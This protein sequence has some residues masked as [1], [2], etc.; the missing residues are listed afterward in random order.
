MAKLWPKIDELGSL[1]ETRLFAYQASLMGHTYHHHRRARGSKAHTTTWY[2]AVQALTLGLPRG[3]D[4]VLGLLAVRPYVLFHW[5]QSEI[6]RWRDGFR[7]ISNPSYPLP[8]Q[9]K[10]TSTLLY[11]HQVQ[12]PNVH[13][14]SIHSNHTPYTR[15]SKHLAYNLDLRLPRLRPHQRR[16]P[17]P[18]HHVRPRLVLV[19]RLKLEC[20]CVVRVLYDVFRFLRC[21]SRSWSFGFG[22]GF[23]FSGGGGRCVGL[24]SVRAGPARAEGDGEEG[25]Y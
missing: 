14:S 22:A 9:T 21:S 2:V 1:N 24:G 11:L 19:L 16:R 7:I 10:L 6:Y 4:V 18:L 23:G 17:L 20:G 25:G 12:L 13:N 3:L 15:S 8:A 5:Y